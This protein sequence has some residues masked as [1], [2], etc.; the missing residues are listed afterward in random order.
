[1]MSWVQVKTELRRKEEKRRQHCFKLNLIKEKLIRMRSIQQ[2]TDL[3]Q[4]HEQY[5]KRMEELSSDILDPFSYCFESGSKAEKPSL[6]VSILKASDQYTDVV[7]K[8]NTKYGRYTVGEAFYVMR[9][10]KEYLLEEY[11]ATRKPVP[12]DDTYISTDY[13][14]NRNELVFEPMEEYDVA[15]EKRWALGVI[16]YYLV[17]GYPA[18]NEDHKVNFYEEIGLGPKLHSSAMNKLINKGHSFPS[19]SWQDL[20]EE[21]RKCIK[22]L[23][24]YHPGN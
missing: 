3:L 9:D 6:I 23:T 8:L 22:G 24:C 1:M 4:E 21:A 7:N 17:T 10:L 5:N 16:Y 14:L 18:L 2:T 15:P 13:Y 11:E 12:A 20:S 19:K